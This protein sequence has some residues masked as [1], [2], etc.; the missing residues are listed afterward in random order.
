M[1][2]AAEFEVFHL[3]VKQSVKCSILLL[4]QNDF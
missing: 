2:H 4:K 3:L 1:R